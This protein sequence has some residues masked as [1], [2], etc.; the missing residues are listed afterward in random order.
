MHLNFT[1]MFVLSGWVVFSVPSVGFSA[2]PMITDDTGTHGSGRSQIELTFERGRER[3]PGLTEDSVHSEAALSYGVTDN[4]DLIVVIPHDRIRSESPNGRV[5]NQ[6]LGDVGLDVKWRFFE[7]G[8]ASIAFT[9]GVTFAT[10]DDAKQLGTGKTSYT[11]FVVTT[12]EPS[13]W[14]LHLQAGY[15]ANRNVIG[16]REGLGHLSIGG[17]L[18][19]MGDRLKLVADWGTITNADKSSDTNIRFLIVGAIYSLTPDFD[20]DVGY[21]KGLTDPETDRTLL[22]GMAARF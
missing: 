3:E 4:T 7:R 19:F 21:K 5:T 16:E 12:I 17:W 2:H 11:A 13:P 6:G 1:K 8:I 15:I 18:N 22:V 20:L 10:G 9:P 14:A